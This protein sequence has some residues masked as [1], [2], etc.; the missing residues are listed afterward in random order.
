MLEGHNNCFKLSTP[1]LVL[2]HF[3]RKGRGKRAKLTGK[4]YYMCKSCMV[5][6]VD[7][8]RDAW[9]WEESGVGIPRDRGG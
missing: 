6:H 3:R 9:S 2:T 7:G 4:G 8:R 1:G 5:W